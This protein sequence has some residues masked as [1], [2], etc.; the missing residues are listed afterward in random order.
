MGEKPDLDF[1]SGDFWGGDPHAALTWLRHHEPVCWNEAA[2]VWGIT[3]YDDVKQISKH[4][5]VWSSAGG[6]RPDSGPTGMMIEQDDPVHWQRRKLVNK[7]FTPQQVRAQESKVRDIVDRLLD[8]VIDQGQCDFVT[9]VAAWL[10]LVMIGDALG[11]DEADHPT[12][13]KWSDDLMRGLG[14]DDPEKLT[15]MMAAF[16]GYTTYMADVIADRRQSPRDDLTSI[17]VHAEVDGDRFD[18]DTL[19]HE[20]LLILIGGDETTR[21]VIT[22]GLYQLLT[23][24]EQWDALVSDR[25]L[26]PSAV[27]EMLRWVS[28]IKNM[29][30]TA[31]RD[32]ELRGRQI[33]EGQKVL[34]LY[35]SANRDEDVFDEP[36]RFDITRAPNEHVAFGFGTH[37]C[38]GNS[39]A[40]LEL[41][42]MFEQLLERV[43]NIH[44]VDPAEPSHR[45]ANF[46]SGYETMKVAW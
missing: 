31:T 12:L 24:R 46:V 6:I 25:A 2:G 27:E 7:G 36:F 39:L 11:F 14:Q 9:D 8:R 4:P 40:R 5:D 10:P 38:L 23:H 20:T 34:L 30:R 1:V 26:L 28:P 21:H 16:E 45:P 32:I 43:P 35:P 42:V 29:A 41:Q 3:K 22:G 18:D 44:L 19:V 13:L 33:R 15:S 17:L 37:F